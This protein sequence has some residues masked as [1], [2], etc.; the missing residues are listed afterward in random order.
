MALSSETLKHL[1]REALPAREPEI[2][3][4]SCLQRVDEYAE[5][6][7]AGAP[8]TEALLLVEQHLEICIEC[9]EEFEL[10]LEALRGL[11]AEE[12]EN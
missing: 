1:V 4:D 11:R 10:L 5:K 7:L 12:D 6:V 2:D 3:C 8:V 9:R